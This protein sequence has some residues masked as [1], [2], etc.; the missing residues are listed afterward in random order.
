MEQRFQ[1]AF[2]VNAQPTKCPPFFSPPRSGLLKPCHAPEWRWLADLAQEP[3]PPE[4]AER[5][6]H[7]KEHLMRYFMV[8]ILLGAT[9]LRADDWTP[10]KDPDPQAILQEARTDTRSKRYETALKKHVWFHEH[11]LTINPAFYG[12]RLSFALS[13]W[14]ELGQAYPPAL[15]KLKEIRDAAQRKVVAGEDTRESFHDMASINEH[16]GEQSKTTEVFEALDEKDPKIAREV[17]DVAQSSLIKCKAYTLVGKYISPKDDFAQMS[18]VYRENRKLAADA[19]F[20]ERHLDFA[21]K[22]FANDATTLVAILTVND[23]MK[24]ANEIATSARAEWDD[25]SFHASLAEAL[26]G[27]VPDPWP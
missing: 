9:A 7:Y 20:G 23:R 10:P 1:W 16:L 26:K 15:T 8:F 18:A 24:E 21:S 14:L 13:Y 3:N 5:W 4:P 25:D 6:L 12:V 11:A 2:P 22:K 17:L 27:V 19:R